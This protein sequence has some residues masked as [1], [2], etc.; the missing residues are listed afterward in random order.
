MEGFQKHRE[1]RWPALGNVPVGVGDKVCRCPAA[2]PWASFPA[3]Q[4]EVIFQQGPEAP[5]AA[6]LWA[7]GQRQWGQ[8][9]WP[10]AG[11]SEHDSLPSHDFPQPPPHCTLCE[12]RVPWRQT[13][14]HRQQGS[15]LI[16][17]LSCC[18]LC[19]GSSGSLGEKRR[20]ALSLRGSFTAGVLGQMRRR[21][22][23]GFFA[24]SSHRAS[25]PSP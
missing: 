15:F 10:A 25:L 12:A 8:P 17:S 3:G 6:T 20:T 22:P 16:C 14:T 13:D 4:V 21:R 19:L 23:L 9:G 18:A 24:F 11:M 5:L 2:L 1:S 7:P